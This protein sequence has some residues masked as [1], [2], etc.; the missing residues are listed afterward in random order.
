MQP[1]WLNEVDLSVQCWVSRYDHHSDILC[2]WGDVW[3]GLLKFV[4]LF[5]NR[6]KKHLF[7]LRR[8]LT[9]QYCIRRSDRST[10]VCVVQE[11]AGDSSTEGEHYIS[12]SVHLEGVSSGLSFY[13]TVPPAV[14]D[15]CHLMDWHVSFDGLTASSRD[16][17]IEIAHVLEGPE[18]IEVT[19]GAN[20]GLVARLKATIDVRLKAIPTCKNLAKL[21]LLHSLQLKFELHN[22]HT[23]STT[24][25]SILL[26]PIVWSTCTWLV[27][28]RLSRYFEYHW[29]CAGSR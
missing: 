26:M 29:L 15:M 27:S 24:V 25:K 18:G 8:F 4:A 21:F 22:G 2:R 28:S 10:R 6:E 13:T 1:F 9:K 11:M 3:S 16:G 5:T 7:G 23:T 20:T 12:R 17:K 14:L 19:L